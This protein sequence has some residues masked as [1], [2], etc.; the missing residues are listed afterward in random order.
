MVESNKRTRA[1]IIPEC[2]SHRAYVC[3]SSNLLHRTE[4]LRRLSEFVTCITSRRLIIL[5]LF[6][7]YYYI[8]F[9]VRAQIAMFC[10]NFVNRSPKTGQPMTSAV[11]VRQG[12]HF[13]RLHTAQGPMIVFPVWVAPKRSGSFLRPKQLFYLLCLTVGER[14]PLFINR[15]ARAK[16]PKTT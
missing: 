1:H 8:L 4:R 14:S 15:Y 7:C 6:Y 12:H 13:Q 11:C 2:H 3:S 5:L 9:R 10:V 16:K